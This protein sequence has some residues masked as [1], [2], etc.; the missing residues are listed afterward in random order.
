MTTP[1]IRWCIG[2]NL[3]TASRKCPKCRKDVSIIHIDSKSQICPIFKNEAARIRSLVDSMYGEG[4][5]DLLIPD[6]RT[7]LYICSSSNRKILINGGIVGSVSQSGEVS[8]NASG[9]GIISDKISK[10][11]VQCDHDSSFFVSKGRNLMASSVKSCSEGLDAGDI[12]VV[13]DDRGRPIAEGVMRMSS[14]EVR[15]SDRGVAVKIRSNETSRAENNAEFND[16]NST[17]EANKQSIDAFSG[18][19]SK[20]ISDVVSSYGYPVVVSFSSDI[21]SEADL[22]LTLDV[23]YRPKVLLKE[24]NEFIDYFIQ[25]HGLD[26]ISDIPEKC[27]LIAEGHLESETGVIVHSPTIDWDPVMVWMYVMSKAEPFDPSYL[28]GRP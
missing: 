24:R 26:T 17:L 9:L 15:S 19:S 28:Q 27:I 3:V 1:R 4:C 13:F 2:C 12:V 10:N 5:G 20:K 21:L 23:G 25:K 6:E 14:D 22:L 11:T 18:D 7:A 16:W 8:L